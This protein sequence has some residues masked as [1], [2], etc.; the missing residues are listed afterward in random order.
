MYE[1][2]F[3]LSLSHTLFF[4]AP[5]AGTFSSQTICQGDRAI[6]PLH[7]QARK[8]QPV[9]HL[10]S[11]QPLTT[12]NVLKKMSSIFLKISSVNVIN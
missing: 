8:I 2:S 1:L 6:L 10:S 3:S 11:K 12:V 5:F 9:L 7:Y 4:L